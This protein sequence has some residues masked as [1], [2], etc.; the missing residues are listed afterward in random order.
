MEHILKA[1]ER[2]GIDPGRRAETLTPAEFV[3][4]SNLFFEIGLSGNE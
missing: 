3:V 1:F 4:F 2:S